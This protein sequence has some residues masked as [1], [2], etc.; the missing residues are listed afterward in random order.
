MELQL[1]ERQAE[2]LG[3]LQ[4]YLAENG[5]PP[6]RPELAKLLGISSTNGVFKHLEALARKGAIELVPNAARGIRILAEQGLP[7][8][9]RVA[10]GSPMLAIE[11]QLGCYPVDPSLFNPR[12]DYLQQVIRSRIEK[13]RIDRIAPKLV[14]DREHRAS[15]GDAADER[16]ALLGKDANPARRVGHE[17]DR[18]FS[19][20]RLQVLEDAI[21][22]GDAE[23]LRKLRAR[24]R[25]PI[26][27]EVFLQDAEDFRLPLSQLQLH[28]PLLLRR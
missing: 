19:R 9:G 7:L 27:G 25:P 1:T 18:P 12:A 24:W 16:Q 23:Q 28:R 22:R 17:L 6:S 15:R 20:E 2:I 11:N 4:E 10:A 8:I 21:G 5:R 14:F 3:I 26:L 13:R